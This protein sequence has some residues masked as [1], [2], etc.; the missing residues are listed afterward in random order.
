VNRP[1]NFA[2]HLVDEKIAISEYSLSASVACGKVRPTNS[3]VSLPLT[4]T[5]V[6]QFCCATED[7]FGIL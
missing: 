1:D 6:R 3:L 7:L 4:D 2:D 5:W